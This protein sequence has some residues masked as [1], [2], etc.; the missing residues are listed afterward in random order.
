MFQIFQYFN[1]RLR[2]YKKVDVSRDYY[3]YRNASGGK[4]TPI[5]ILKPENLRCIR[6]WIKLNFQLNITVQDLDDWRNN[7]QD[8]IE[9]N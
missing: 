4:E 8:V 5:V 1:H 7:G 3:I 9:S 6:K 2:G